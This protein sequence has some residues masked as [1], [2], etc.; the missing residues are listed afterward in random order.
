M[1]TGGFGGEL[2]G[3]VE[4][5]SS[6]PAPFVFSYISLADFYTKVTI[7]A[8]VMGNRIYWFWGLL[9]FV[10]SRTFMQPMRFFNFILK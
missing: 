8:V 4:D 10:G 6:G 9:H 2:V 1:G 3:L 5:L 7:V